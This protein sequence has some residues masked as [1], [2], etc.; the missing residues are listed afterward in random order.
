MLLFS[1]FYYSTENFKLLNN[2]TIQDLHQAKYTESPKNVSFFNSLFV[3]RPLILIFLGFKIVRLLAHEYNY[4][5]T[6]K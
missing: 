3:I 4:T 5:S 2:A 6:I 1:L